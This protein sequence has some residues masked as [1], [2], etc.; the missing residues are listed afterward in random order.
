MYF[1]CPY[2]NWAINKQVPSRN[3][4][5]YVA[6]LNFVCFPLHP[7]Y[8]FDN[9]VQF[10]RCNLRLFITICL[11][12]SYMNELPI[13][14]FTNKIV[15]NDTFLVNHCSLFVSSICRWVYVNGDFI[16]DG[17]VLLWYIFVCQVKSN[18]EISAV[19]FR[20]HHLFVHDLILFCVIS[21][22]G[23]PMIFNTFYQHQAIQCS[24][25]KAKLTI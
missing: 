9:L 10:R 24:D 22:C 18:K 16:F 3:I 17:M 25:I 12:G 11:Y 5:V 19:S 15:S 13:I 7:F 2:Y 1:T 14:E 23:I 6:S 8:H 21:T 4:Q 20:L